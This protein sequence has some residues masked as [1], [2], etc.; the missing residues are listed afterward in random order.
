MLFFFLFFLSYKSDVRTTKHNRHNHHHNH[1]RDYLLTST[2]IIF[3]ISC[4]IYNQII[5]YHQ[6]MNQLKEFY[7]MVNV[8]EHIQQ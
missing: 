5:I 4:F 7:V 1:N 8:E 2:H 3:T 6:Q